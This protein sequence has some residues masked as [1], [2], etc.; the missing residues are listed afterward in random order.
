M[1]IWEWET[2]FSVVVD[3]HEVFCCCWIEFICCCCCF[4][5]LFVYQRLKQILPEML[6]IFIRCLFEIVVFL[7]CYFLYTIVY[8]II[9]FML[10]EFFVCLV[11]FCF[12]S[13]LSV[14]L[15]LSKFLL[16]NKSSGSY[17]AHLQQNCVNNRFKYNIEYRFMRTMTRSAD[18]QR[19]EERK[20]ETW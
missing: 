3:H 6:V 19:K 5:F 10:K 2:L 4:F 7:L 15:S 16:F 9:W 12:V 14:F 13:P 20:K 1:I 8:L 11:F 17:S 18:I